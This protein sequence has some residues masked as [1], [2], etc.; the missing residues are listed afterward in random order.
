MPTIQNKQQTIDLKQLKQLTQTPSCDLT[1]NWFSANIPLM[2]SL[3]LIYSTIV[4]I[5]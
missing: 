3:L 5:Q 1:Q 2:L 4:C